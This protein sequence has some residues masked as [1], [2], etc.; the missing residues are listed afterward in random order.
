[1]TAAIPIYRD[2]ARPAPRIRP[3]KAFGHFRRLVADKEDTAQVFL[4]SECL[5]NKAFLDHARAFCE[6]PRGQA[7]MASE[8]SLPALLDDHVAILPMSDDSV[9][10]AYVNFMRRERLTASGLVAEAEKVKAG[11]PRYD[12]QLQWFF[13]RLRDTHDLAHV[14][15][16]YG[17]D[18]LG[19]QCV[20]GFTWGQ[21]HAWTDLFLS[22][23]GALEMKRRIRASAPVLAAV[24][25]AQRN[26]KAA[27]RIFEQDVRALLAEPI[28]DARTRLGIGKPTRYTQAHQCFRAQ[29]VDPY[30]FLAAA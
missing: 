3:F 8:P 21:Y 29:G 25:E 30:N 18:A 5:P 6:S 26:G 12:D 27:G 4:I 19:E 20:L 23:A 14:L 17:R 2:P 28:E 7:L 15:T 1:M 16:G 11:R 10:H 9:G 22:W 13:N 24:R